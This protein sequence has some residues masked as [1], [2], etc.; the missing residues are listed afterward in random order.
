L[1]WVQ[2]GFLGLCCYNDTHIRAP[3]GE[4]ANRA[5]EGCLWQI[6]SRHAAPAATSQPPPAR[7]TAHMHPTTTLAAPR[8]AVA[9]TS[10]AARPPRKPTRRSL[11]SRRRS[12]RC[13]PGSPPTHREASFQRLPNAIHALLGN[14]SFV[15]FLRRAVAEHLR[16]LG[17]HGAT[18]VSGEALA[19]APS[20][21]KP[22]GATHATALRA[23]VGRDR[24]TGDPRR[25]ARGLCTGH[26]RPRL[27]VG[28]AVNN[29]RE[30]FRPI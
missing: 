29:G 7:T 17:A 3:G 5:P 20:G 9:A 25:S 10:H 23:F 19:L 26:R 30:D 12:A 8:T 6:L 2:N 22:G 11:R 18:H 27:G 21:H 28:F 4:R 14:G 15:L 1:K 16:R 24:R 13:P